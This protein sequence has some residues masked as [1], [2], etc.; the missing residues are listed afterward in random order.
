MLAPIHLQ[1]G[2]DE[3]A[4]LR[5][6]DAFQANFVSKQAGIIKRVL[7]RNRD[8]SYADLVFFKSKEA[9]D[10]VCQAEATS[11]ECL[12]FFKIM[13]TSDASLPGMGILSF[14]HMKS[15]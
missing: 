8:G 5:A 15:Y 13:K 9:A 1:D 12:E 6:S 7:L 4:L 14:E 10:E 2:V 11:P 3:G